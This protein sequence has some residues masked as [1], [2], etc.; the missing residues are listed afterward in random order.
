V[1]LGLH[2][3]SLASSNRAEATVLLGRIEGSCRI[4][5]ADECKLSFLSDVSHDASTPIIAARVLA[6]GVVLHEHRND[7]INPNTDLSLLG[8]TVLADGF[9][10]ARCGQAYILELQ[11]QAT[12]DVD[13]KSIATTR[14]I[15]CPLSVP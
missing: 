5:A 7:A 1:V 12:D 10:A 15:P 9:L 14:E 3:F 6:N 8:R 4:V 13:F 11:A 2:L